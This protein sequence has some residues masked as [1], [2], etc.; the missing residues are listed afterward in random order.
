MVLVDVGV[1]LLLKASGMRGVRDL[2]GLESN[3]R[4]GRRHMILI[5]DLCC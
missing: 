2:K 1:M 4:N 5:S 3:G